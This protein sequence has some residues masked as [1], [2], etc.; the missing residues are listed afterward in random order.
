MDYKLEFLSKLFQKTSKKALENYVLTRLWH[1]LDDFDV[2]IIP[3]QYVNRHEDKFALT[4]VYFPQVG[5]K[6]HED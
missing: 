5:P 4:D 6:H 3:Q 2:K 1:K